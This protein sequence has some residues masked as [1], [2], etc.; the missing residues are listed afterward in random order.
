[1]EHI[2]LGLEQLWKH[3]QEAG[4]SAVEDKLGCMLMRVRRHGLNL[5][6]TQA[7]LVVV[8]GTRSSDSPRSRG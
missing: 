3:H 7:Y 4:N 2:H 6:R 5:L 8:Q 1:M